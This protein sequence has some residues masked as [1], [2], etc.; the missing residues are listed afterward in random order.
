MPE[1]SWLFQDDSETGIVQGCGSG[2]EGLGLGPGVL[3]KPLK[4]F[5]QQGDVWF[6]L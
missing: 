4:Y 6:V 2:V 1:A 5:K 3:G